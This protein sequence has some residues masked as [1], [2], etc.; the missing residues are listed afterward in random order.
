MGAGQRKRATGDAGVEEA[1]A[2]QHGLYLRWN[3]GLGEEKREALCLACGPRDLDSRFGIQERAQRRIGERH[4]IGLRA[5]SSR[6]GIGPFDAPQH[7]I[8]TG[9]GLRSVGPA[10]RTGRGERHLA[11]RAGRLHEGDDGFLV[12]R[13]ESVAARDAHRGGDIFHRRAEFH[14]LRPPGRG[15]I[16]DDFIDLHQLASGLA[17]RGFDTLDRRLGRIVG[18]EMGG[19]LGR[20]MACG[21]GMLRQI[22]ER[23]HAAAIAFFVAAPEQALRAGLMA[24]RIEAKAVFGLAH[25][26]VDHPR[27]RRGAAI[28]APTGEDIGQRNDV[29]LGVAA[30]DAERVKLQDF[31]SQIFVASFAAALPRE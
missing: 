30:I 19:E 16:D 7:G 18:N 5:K 29:V 2:G 6:G 27:H 12:E 24:R 11:H 4:R 3:S 31:A 20:D 28:D 25:P 13:V 15:I 14:R 1:S 8:R 21:R 10:L 23:L 26:C 22:G 9:P 17:E